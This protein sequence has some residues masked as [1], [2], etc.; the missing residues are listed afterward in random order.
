M[1]HGL[2]RQATVVLLGLGLAAVLCRPLYWSMVDAPWG[3]R[4]L[5]H[6][7]VERQFAVFGFIALISGALAWMLTAARRNAH[8]IQARP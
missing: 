4:T 3:L 6:L 2:N 8:R 1:G 7:T 5:G